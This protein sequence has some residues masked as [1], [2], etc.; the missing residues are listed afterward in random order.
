MES[1]LERQCKHSHTA[2]NKSIFEWLP[3]P[4]F[5]VCPASKVIVLQYAYAS[6]ASSHVTQFDALSQ[7]LVACIIII[8]FIHHNVVEKNKQTKSDNKKHDK[9]NVSTATAIEHE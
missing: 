2:V 6:L 7:V 9:I 8:N 5:D 1:D 3:V 4:T